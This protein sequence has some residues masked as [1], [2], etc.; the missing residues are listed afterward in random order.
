MQVH[1]PS[2]VLHK[3]PFSTSLNGGSRP[4]V[5][6]RVGPV[7]FYLESPGECDWLIKAAVEAKRLLLGEPEPVPSSPPCPAVSGT[8][9]PCTS[10]LSPH[11]MP[12]R[13]E[14]GNEWDDGR[15]PF[16][17]DIDRV[18]AASRM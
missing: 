14:A 1:G 8:G 16:A 17:D 10:P 3:N 12:H 6:L 2:Q 18:N 7:H 11:P 5:D 9:T 4:F 15:E 13:D